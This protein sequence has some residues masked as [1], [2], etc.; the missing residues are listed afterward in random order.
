MKILSNHPELDQ[1]LPRHVKTDWGFYACIVITIVGFLFVGRPILILVLNYK[2]DDPNVSFFMAFLSI[3]PIIFLG[4][5]PYFMW[6][7]IKER[8]FLKWGIVAEARVV[9]G[10]EIDGGKGARYM[11]VVYGFEDADGNTVVDTRTLPGHSDNTKRSQNILKKL[12]HPVVLYDPKNSKRNLLYPGYF[13][14]CISPK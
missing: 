8:K 6:M 7:Y 9:E 12:E 14:K 13:V 5:I 2:W 1:P 4:F 3:I 10:P 11:K